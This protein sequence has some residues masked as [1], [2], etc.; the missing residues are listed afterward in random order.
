MDD[1]IN[2]ITH[3]QSF[4]SEK[5]I[6]KSAARVFSAV[7]ANVVVVSWRRERELLFYFT[8]GL[9]VSLMCQEHNGCV[10]LSPGALIR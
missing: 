5:N 1:F 9:R 4:F 3:L 2:L 8:T 6:K 10:L 7:G